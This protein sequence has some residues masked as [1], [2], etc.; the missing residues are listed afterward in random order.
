M[1]SH[2]LPPTCCFGIP[3]LPCGRNLS[4]VHRTAQTS[5]YD[6]SGLV[7]NDEGSDPGRIGTWVFALFLVVLVMIGVAC[8]W[9]YLERVD[10]DKESA[11]LA[12]LD[13]PV[14]SRQSISSPASAMTSLRKVLCSAFHTVTCCVV[15]TR[16]A[17]YK[18]GEVLCT[19]LVALVDTNT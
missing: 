14:L 12:W 15:E 3:L 16:F 11:L 18:R 4:G 5:T 8:V 6:F 19:G 2:N 13:K 7:V 10:L 17:E 9:R 1:C